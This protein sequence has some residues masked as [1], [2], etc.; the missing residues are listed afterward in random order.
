MK[1][2]N[3]TLVGRLGHTPRIWAA[4]PQI[5]AVGS[6]SPPVNHWGYLVCSGVCK[7]E[8]VTRTVRNFR[9]QLWDEGS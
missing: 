4:S 8:L 6:L 7:E 1:C 2:W 3:Y 9:T 5:D